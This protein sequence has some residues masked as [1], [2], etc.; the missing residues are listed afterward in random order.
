[1]SKYIDADRLKAEIKRLKKHS[2][3]S[4]KEW[5]GE[6][7]NQNAFAEDCRIS[8][9]DKLLSFIDS[10]QQEQSSLPS[11]L[12]EAAHDYAWEKQD[13]VYDAEGEIL[14]DY[15]PRYDAFKAGAEWMAGQGVTC[16]GKVFTSAFTSYVK[17]PGIEELLKD[18][19]P[20]DT[21][22]IVQIRKKQ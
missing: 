4:K 20:E 22:V 14:M 11:N 3:E 8:S 9:F 15:G 5:I 13:M 1:M 6:G 12:D 19:F 21:E 17:T 2:E 18:V 16:E 7:Y 10:L